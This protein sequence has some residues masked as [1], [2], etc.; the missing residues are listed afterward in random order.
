MEGL[1]NFRE[2]NGSQKERATIG[3]HLKQCPFCM[4]HLLELQELEFLAKERGWENPPLRRVKEFKQVVAK[5]TWKPN[6]KVDWM[7]IQ[8]WLTPRWAV[9]SA[10]TNAAVV[11]FFFGYLEVRSL[12]EE[13]QAKRINLE[14][15]LNQKTLEAK[16]RAAELKEKTENERQLQA[17]IQEL[18]VAR[19][20]R[21]ADEEP[22]ERQAEQG[23]GD[24]AKPVF[25]GG[26][27]PRP[28]APAQYRSAPIPPSVGDATLYAVVRTTLVLAEARAGASILR[29]LSKGTFVR[30][31]GENGQYLQVEFS[32]GR[33]GYVLRRDVKRA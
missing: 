31:M 14:Q 33:Y 27:A 8:Y 2:G 10:L 28:E 25:R 17:Q 19:Q 1:E 29:T 3:V 32:Q 9:S 16:Q 20:R 6:L 21:T 26:P 30:V 15:E 5:K 24:T 22:T 4:N 12:V 13:E 11:L 7:K 18:T 23:V